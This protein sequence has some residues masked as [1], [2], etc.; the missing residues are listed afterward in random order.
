MTFSKHVL[1]ASSLPGGGYEDRNE[2]VLLEEACCLE[3][4]TGMQTMTRQ[5]AVSSKRYMEI[6]V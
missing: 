3:M 2:Q 4:Q 6:T 5:F 1:S